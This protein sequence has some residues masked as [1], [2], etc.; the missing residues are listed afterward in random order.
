MLSEIFCAIFNDFSNVSQNIMKSTHYTWLVIE[1]FSMVPRAWQ[2]VP[3]FGEI[4]T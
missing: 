2:E 4:S 1:G 3:W